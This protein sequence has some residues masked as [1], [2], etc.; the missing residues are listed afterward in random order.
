[1]D[2][3]T[4]Q[5]LDS[6]SLDFTLIF[7][8]DKSGTLVKILEQ[9]GGTDTF[10]NSITGKSYTERF[11]NTV[12]I[13]PTAHVGATNGV[14]SHLTVPGGRSRAFGCRQARGGSKRHNLRGR[15]PPAV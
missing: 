7:L 11:H 9:V 14:I 15:P 4:F 8:S 10:I 13:D 5:I 12:D 6:Y 3:G 1:V 2:C